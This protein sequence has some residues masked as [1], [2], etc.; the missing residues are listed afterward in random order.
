MALLNGKEV[1][2]PCQC[3]SCL[4][5]IL[6]K[7]QGPFCPSFCSQQDLKYRENILQPEQTISFSADA[8]YKG[9]ACHAQHATCPHHVT[10]TDLLTCTLQRARREGGFRNF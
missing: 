5:D 10:N 6:P 8:W 3:H 2:E 7:K 1:H 4:K 9:C